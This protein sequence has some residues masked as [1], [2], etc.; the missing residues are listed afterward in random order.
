MTPYPN[1]C[2]EQ[3]RNLQ[4]QAMS[5]YFPDGRA[6]KRKQLFD[7]DDKGQGEDHDEGAKD[8][9]KGTASVKGKDEGTASA[10]GNDKCHEEQPTIR[11]TKEQSLIEE[12]RHLFATASCEGQAELR[13]RVAVAMGEGKGNNVDPNSMWARQ[14][15]S[16]RM[17][18][19]YSSRMAVHDH[20]YSP[21]EDKGY[22]KGKGEDKGYGEGKGQFS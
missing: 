5:L 18:D 3:V 9:G 11:A 10:K 20:D 13:Q 7:T 6:V 16:K 17:P 2:R 4:A 8:K 15:P 14:V 19:D 22:V 1:Y 12:L 21:R